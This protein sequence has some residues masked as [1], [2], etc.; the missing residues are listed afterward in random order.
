MWKTSIKART[1]LAAVLALLAACGQSAAPTFP[2]ADRPVARIVSPRWS[3][4]EARDRKNEAGEVMDKARIAPGMTVADIG[5]GE[6]YYTIRL[7]QRVGPSGRVLAQ[8]IVPATRD[9]L[10]ERVTRER[11]Q[12]VSV[13]LGEP[14]DPKLPDNSFDRVFMI[15]MYHEI[16]QPYE[17][18]WRLRPSLKPDGLV[19]VVDAD[20]PTQNHGTPPALLKCE[21]AAIGYQLVSTEDMPSAG[22]YLAAFKAV[23]P[24]PY[25]A[26][27]KGCRLK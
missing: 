13:R 9:A 8:D 21:F 23:G 15:H 17:F 10:A 7:A 26:A 1:A 12:S 14:A 5:A 16:A 24:R 27:I 25:P 18:L 3:T 4:E 22:G 19:I 6:G 11:L 20:R 2:A